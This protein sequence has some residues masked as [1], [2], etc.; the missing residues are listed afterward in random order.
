MQEGNH[1]PNLNAGARLGCDES[2]P[3][4]ESSESTDAHRL[5]SHEYEH[6]VTMQ[7]VIILTTTPHAN[8]LPPQIH[9]TVQHVPLLHRTV[10]THLHAA[11]P[12][13]LLLHLTLTHLNNHYFFFF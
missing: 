6:A 11:S 2:Q 1:S 9:S 3:R 12:T 10:A 8:H 13:H 4:G 5:R 7:R